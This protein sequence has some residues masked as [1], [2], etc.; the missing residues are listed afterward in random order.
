MKR[1]TKH[2]K[3][4]RRLIHAFRLCKLANVQDTE[5][6]RLYWLLRNAADDDEALTAAH[7]ASRARTLKQAGQQS[8]T[9]YR[10]KRAEDAAA[11]LEMQA[12]LYTETRTGY[13][14]RMESNG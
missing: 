3:A 7:S 1:K 6:E 14:V 13:H 10:H 11:R 5:T 8:A 12:N 2:G 4:Q 9:A